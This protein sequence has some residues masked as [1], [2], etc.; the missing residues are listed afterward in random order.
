MNV[1]P[2]SPGRGNPAAPRAEWINCL[3]GIRGAIDVFPAEM[4]APDGS[5]G[6]AF[7]FGADGGIEI[8]PDFRSREIFLGEKLMLGS[9]RLEEEVPVI[10]RMGRRLLALCVVRSRASGWAERYRFPLWT[11]FEAETFE[12]V[13]TV[14][15]PSDVP[16]A[17]KRNGL[18]PE[19]CLVSP[20]GLTVAV[21]F[22]RVADLFLGNADDGARPEK[23]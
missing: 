16:A 21:A 3:T 1:F 17:M 13:E 14:R 19:E 7:R 11:L 20:Y 12:A 18:A 10:L 6:V 5:P 8:V 15:S 4:A 2:Q 22:P 23:S 9:E